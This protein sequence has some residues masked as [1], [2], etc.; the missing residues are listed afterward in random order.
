MIQIGGVYTT[1]CQE[2]GILLQ[3]YAKK[4]GGVSRYFSNV[5]GSG[6]DLT[7]LQKDLPVQT[8]GGSPK[9]SH[10]KTSHQAVLD[11]VPPRGLQLLR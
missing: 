1:F 4:M 9:A 10:I 5:L 8:S 2:E 11:R 3:K 7:L 6:V